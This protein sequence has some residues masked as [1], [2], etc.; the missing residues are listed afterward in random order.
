MV[1]QSLSHVRFFVTPWTAVK[2]GFP[3]H[4]QLPKLTQTHV[5][6]VSGAIQPSHP[7]SSPS[8][9][10]FNLPQH[11]GHFQWVSSLHQVVQVLESFSFSISSSNEYSGLI[12][13]RFDWFDLLI[14]QTTLKS[15]LQHHRLKAS[16]LWHTIFFMVQFS[17]EYEVRDKDLIAFISFVMKECL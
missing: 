14:V 7:L 11:Q 4:H 12:S 9:P 10:A 13:F 3:V 15:L 2:P 16:L 5:H 1:F 17:Q 8:P 6:W